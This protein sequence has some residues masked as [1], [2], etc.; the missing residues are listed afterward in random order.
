MPKT[1]ALNFEIRQYVFMNYAI[2]YVGDSSGLQP[3]G[4]AGTLYLSL[5]TSDP[6]AGDQE[7]SE[8]TYTSYVRQG[9]DR[10]TVEWNPDLNIVANF[11][12]GTGGGGT[13]TYIGIGTQATGAG[14]LLYCGVLSN[15]VAC[16]DGVTP[17]ITSGTISET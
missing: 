1:N 3:S 12:M 6:E 2:E 13:A 5:H 4:T 14:R 16:G 15:A 11:P 17:R 9:V 10:N 7:T 8:V